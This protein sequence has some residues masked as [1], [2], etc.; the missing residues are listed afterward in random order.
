MYPR[1]NTP[2]CTKQACGFRDNYSAITKNGYGVYG[3]SGDKPIAQRTWKSK[4]QYQYNFLC[5]VD[6]KVWLIANEFFMACWLIFIIMIYFS[7]YYCEII[8]LLAHGLYFAV[9][10]SRW[11]STF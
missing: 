4:Q 8:D 7:I 6:H 9:F 3:L 1:A 10:I 11:V 2:G 5:D